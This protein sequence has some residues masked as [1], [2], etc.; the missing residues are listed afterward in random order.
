MDHDRD[1]HGN[2]GEGRTRR[3][4]PR[5][6]EQGHRDWNFR[7][8]WNDIYNINSNIKQKMERGKKLKSKEKREM[9][10]RLVN[11]VR[12]KVPGAKRNI[13]RQIIKDMKTKYSVTFSG[14]LAKG[15]LAKTSMCKRMQDKFDNDKRPNKKTIMEKEAPSIKAAYGCLKWRVACLP[16]D[17]TM[18]SLQEV[19]QAL[20]KH[21]EEVRPRSWDWE[22][23]EGGMKKTY[24]L[25][26]GDINKQAQEIEKN[27]KRPPAE[28]LTEITLTETLRDKW[29]FLTVPRVMLQHFQVLTNIDFSSKLISFLEEDIKDIVTYLIATNKE[30][31]KKIKRRMNRSPLEQPNPKLAALILLLL[32]RFKEEANGLFIIVDVSNL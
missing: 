31:T 12:N 20:K 23:I 2:S 19:Q 13:F 24:G 18:E 8:N 32:Q 1:A 4:T 22:S 6:G 16:E 28:A 27:K 21:F 7:I 10:K 26:R 15:K 14:E 29:P 9:V 5:Q 17:E 30:N 11:Q 25:Q 3:E